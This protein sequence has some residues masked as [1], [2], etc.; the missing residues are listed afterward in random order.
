M[1]D[2]AAQLDGGLQHGS[3]TGAPRR[4]L[5]PLWAAWGAAPGDRSAAREQL[6]R[7]SAQGH[8]EGLEGEGVRPAEPA[9]TALFAAEMRILWSPALA[10]SLRMVAADTQAGNG[11]RW[12]VT[13]RG[14]CH[15]GAPPPMVAEGWMFLFL[16]ASPRLA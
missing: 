9:L 8:G 14:I 16:S 4:P 6:G 15:G 13:L 11:S 7:R 2:A 3:G 5:A 12:R 1:G 10:G